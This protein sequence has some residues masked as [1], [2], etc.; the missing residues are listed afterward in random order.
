MNEA[1]GFARKR[2]FVSPQKTQI[3]LTSFSKQKK[4]NK[5]P[6]PERSA[7]S[8]SY[9]TITAMG[10]TINS[11][12]SQ[13]KLSN[14][15]FTPLAEED[16]ED[17]IRDNTTG[18]SQQS[19]PSITETDIDSDSTFDSPTNSFITSPE[20]KLLSR[21]APQALRKIRTVRKALMDNSLRDELKAVLGKGSVDY[22]S[23]ELGGDP[24]NNTEN[25]RSEDDK[26]QRSEEEI[27]NTSGHTQKEE[28]E[29]ASSHME[30]EPEEDPQLKQVQG[31]QEN[32][33]KTAPQTR[34]KPQGKGKNVSFTAAVTKGPTN[35]HSLQQG[36]IRNPHK[37]ASQSATSQVEQGTL[38]PQCSTQTPARVDKIVTLKKNNTRAHIHRY[39]LRFKTIAAKSEEESHQVIIDTLQRFLAIVL[40]AEPKT[41]YLLI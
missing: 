9:N 38:Y 34:D 12:P 2:T 36:N 28:E 23:R 8:R 30:T 16:N 21:K 39:T 14:N 26:T 5:S 31:G 19:T 27:E 40:Q 13:L 11:P 1:T 33:E 25:S 7:L 24:S 35:S 17:E 32:S 10:H 15:P 6:T 41:F 18:E 3:S 20:K 29:K 22:I 37:Q 4:Q